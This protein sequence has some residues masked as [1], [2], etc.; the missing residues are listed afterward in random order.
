MF[1]A[2]FILPSMLDS[3]STLLFPCV[4]WTIRLR[5]GVHFW[6]P[7]NLYSFTV[8]KALAVIEQSTIGSD[9]LT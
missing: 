9:L 6:C 5:G 8:E 3:F 4:T 7:P 1:N 2:R